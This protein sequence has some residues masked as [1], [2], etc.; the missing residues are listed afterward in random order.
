VVTVEREVSQLV[1]ED[2]FELAERASRQMDHRQGQ[3]LTSLLAALIP[4]TRAG[5]ASRI[6]AIAVVELKPPMGQGRLDLLAEG[7]TVSGMALRTT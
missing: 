1:R 5:G 7:R 4:T 2:P 3:L 6:G